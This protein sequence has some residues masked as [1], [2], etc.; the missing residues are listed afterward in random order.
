MD[1]LPRP[2]K[3]G[4]IL[5]HGHTHIPACEEFDGCIYMN[6]GSV[7]L[8]KADSPR[9]YMLLQDGCFVWKTLEGKTWLRD[10]ANSQG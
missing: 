7:S 1:F 8:P 3:K 6:P 9:G 10:D 4:D 2:M 5:L